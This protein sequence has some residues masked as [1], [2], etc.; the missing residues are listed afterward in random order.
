MTKYLTLY[1]KIETS[2]D[3]CIYTWLWKYP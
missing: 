1:F 2:M 3:I